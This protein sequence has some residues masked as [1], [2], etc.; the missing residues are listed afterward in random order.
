MSGPGD[1]RHT[2]RRFLAVS[3][4]SLATLVAGCSSSD[5]ETP[6][7]TSTRVEPAWTF[8][9]DRE[10]TAPTVAHGHVYVGCRDKRLYA[11]D[12]RRGTVDW[13][14]E[15]GGYVYPTPV[16]TDDRVFVGAED[17]NLY[18][19]DPAT[20]RAEWT[21]DTF[22]AVRD[23]SVGPERVYGQFQRDDDAGARDDVYGFDR[24]TGE[25]TFRYETV[26]DAMVPT[27]ADGT[28]YV[29][30][31]DTDRRRVTPGVHAV[32]LATGDDQWV[33][34][35]SQ[36]PVSAIPSRT[37]VVYDDVVFARASSR[38][39]SGRTFALDRQTG[40]PRWRLLTPGLGPPRL[41]VHDGTVFALI[42]DRVRA[43]D[44]ATGDS[45]WETRVRSDAPTTFEGQYNAPVIADG[46]LY[47]VGVESNDRG[48]LV[49]LDAATGRRQWRTTLPRDTTFSAG[50]PAVG[51]D[52]IFASERY[53]DTVYAFPAN[54]TAPPTPRPSATSTP[55]PTPSLEVDRR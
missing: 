12:A 40:Q 22:H 38:G 26:G 47:A 37:S 44:A 55:T 18:A 16:V 39:G 24:E 5:D 48:L 13:R 20:G 31:R 10:V 53:G 36:R 52:R 9:A 15:T 27:V 34:D 46:T 21:V 19:L 33:F 35:P 43:L 7:T 42:G 41:L 6:T 45:T 54:P 1:A 3:G 4:T 49:A 28:G 8:T 23:V 25:R 30:V 50:S 14:F 2:R 32:D 29:A 11:L 51:H 17:G